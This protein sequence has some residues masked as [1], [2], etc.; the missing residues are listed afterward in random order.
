VQANATRPTKKEAVAAART[1]LADKLK[2]AEHAKDETF[3]ALA[4]DY[5]ELGAGDLEATTL[6][7]YRSIY[8]SHVA[9][10]F[11]RR[12]AAEIEPTEVLRYK[13]RKL[14]AGLSPN[15]VERHMSLIRA[16]HGFGVRMRR[17]SWNAGDAVKS[18]KRPKA[19]N[20]RRSLTAEEAKTLLSAALVIR[21]EPDPPAPERAR[22]WRY[23]HCLCAL[24]ILAGLRRGEDVGLKRDDL[25]LDPELPEELAGFSILYLPNNLVQVPG[26]GK[27]LKGTKSTKEEVRTVLLPPLLTEAL[28]AELRRQAPK[29][30]ADPGWNSEGFV[31]PNAGASRATR[32]PSATP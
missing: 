14:K 21:D 11:D 13:V 9:K 26:V 10:A 31:F 8:R 24:S 27:R 5:F 3:A 15:S 16:I 28:R 19:K 32:T 30:L 18:S 1:K 20:R 6:Q 25:D 12:I 2:G 22:G 7:G 23:L 29:R 17:L 4:A